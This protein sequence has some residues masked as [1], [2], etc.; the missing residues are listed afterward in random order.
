MTMLL[1]VMTATKFEEDIVE[2][3][4]PHTPEEI[5]EQ[6]EIAEYIFGIVAKRDGKEFDDTKGIAW[7][8]G[9]AE[10]EK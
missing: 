3:P 4:G 6:D 2:T 7:K 8:R 10:G 5:R 9:W 1:C